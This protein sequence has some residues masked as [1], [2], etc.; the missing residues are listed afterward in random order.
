MSLLP[1]QTASAQQNK[2]VVFNVITNDVACA[3]GSPTAS[4]STIFVASTV[5]A[6]GGAGGACFANVD[7]ITDD[8]GNVYVEVINHSCGFETGPAIAG[9]ICVDAIVGVSSITVRFGLASTNVPFTSTDF[10][11][12]VV[13]AEYAMSS[14]AAAFANAHDSQYGPTGT[15]LTVTD[16]VSNSVVV[17][18][19]DSDTNWSWALVDITFSGNDYLVC[20]G[21]TN[22]DGGMGV[23]VPTVAPSDY[24]TFTLEEHFVGGSGTSGGAMY[25]WD[26][27][28][29][30][31]VVPPLTLACPVD[32]GTA[33]VGV[34]YSAFLVVAGGVPA[35]TFAII[36]GSL[37]TGLTLDTSTGE[38]SGTPTTAATYTYSAQVT[39]SLG[40]TA[41]T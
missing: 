35:Y 17:T 5:M 13:V 41:T 2:N 32:G 34:P 6:G 15:V 26:G 10:N 23:P 11:Q 36:G 25:Y 18:I 24:G 1:T 27:A 3:L 33:A 12:C 21:M 14:D 39:D 28:E 37:P 19:L 40:N 16:S 9:Y 31:A 4:G 30:A 29:L 22:P 20:F 38:I 7:S 8:Q